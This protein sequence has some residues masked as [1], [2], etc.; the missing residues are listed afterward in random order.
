[1]LLSRAPDQFVHPA[2]LYRDDSEYLA[3]LLPFIAD[4]LARDDPVAV[5]VPGGR[6]A[7]LSEA[8]G[9]RASEV[10]MLDMMRAG[11]NPGR[12]IPAVLREFADRHPDRHVRVV[13]E[14]IWAGR[15]DRE[16]P[17][18]VQHEA[19]TN[20]AFTG[21]NVT[22]VCPYDAK[23]LAPQVITDAYATHPLVWD[24]NT[25][26]ASAEYAPERVI[27]AYNQPLH[28]PLNAPQWIVRAKSDLSAT[29][30]FVSAHAEKL[31]L[32]HD[33]ILDLALMVNELATNSLVHT[34]GG[35]R[36]RIWLDEAEIVCA[37]ADQG[38]ITDPLAGRRPSLPG[39]FGGRGL[40]LVNQF[41]DLVRMHTTPEGTTLH[42]HCRLEDAP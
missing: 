7:M 29:R 20:L 14:P 36:V 26:E 1:V 27:A 31:G 10:W 2:L 6:L 19:L 4:G 5:V 41:A 12:I 22:M 15:S 16:Y 24:L 42:V 23:R 25:S 28:A 30:R 8:L 40:L 9:R 13:G 17:A 37:V 18:C 39:Q 34:G 33:R 3:G 35:C 38:H 32:A 11:R 21:R